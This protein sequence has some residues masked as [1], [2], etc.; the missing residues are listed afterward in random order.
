VINYTFPESPEIYIHRTGRTGRAGRSGHAI[1]LIG[2]TEVGSFYDLQLLYK[3][4]PEE[5]TLPSEAEVRSRREG[6]KL[7]HL[8]ALLPGD[9]G[10]E[11]HSLAR[12]LMNAIDAERLVGSLLRGALGTAKPEPR[13]QP[14]ELQPEPEP[15]PSPPRQEERAYRPREA[16]DRG[17]RGERRPRGHGERERTSR[18]RER[19]DRGPRANG[20]PA[21]PS[22]PADDG[23]DFWEVWSEDV[24]RTGPTAAPSDAPAAVSATSPAADEPAVSGEVRLYVNLG[25]KDGATAESVAELL[26]SSGASVPAADVELMNTHSYINVTKE[27]ADTLCTTVSGRDHNGRTVICERARPPRRR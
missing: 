15:R 10:P 24:G 20:K 16:M 12:R 4:R 14:A 18:D 3:I 11:W 7:L 26:S 8:R 19:R 13:P 17:G 25:R 22:S 23:R 6:E 2:P 1:S 5:R 27:T 9:A 21:A